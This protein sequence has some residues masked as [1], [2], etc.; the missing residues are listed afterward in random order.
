MS[1]S[2]KSLNF[3]IAKKKKITKKESFFNYQQNFVT[4]YKKIFPKS[5]DKTI[6][7]EK[8]SKFFLYKK[9]FNPRTYNLSSL[10]R[11]KLNQKLGLNIPLQHTVLT[12]KDI[13]FACFYL[14]ECVQGTQNPTDIDDLK[15]RK[16]KPSGELIQAQFATGLFRFEKIIREKL[17][18]DE[19]LKINQ[20]K[21][22]SK[23][24][25]P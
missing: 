19:K 12:A 3:E 18:L 5:Q 21:T 9:F 2:D 24:S 22:L 1:L 16:I 20:E 23:N 4:L 6:E 15:N 11:L 7:I 13:L 14:I 25:R 8:L 10:G 17:I